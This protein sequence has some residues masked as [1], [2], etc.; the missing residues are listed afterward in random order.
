MQLWSADATVPLVGCKSDGMLGPQEPP[1]DGIIHL[2]LDRDI[3]K[4]MSYY[5]AQDEKGG[6]L[7]P[8]GWYCFGIYGSS[9]ASLFISPNPINQKLFFDPESKWKGFDGPIVLLSFTNGDTSGRFEVAEVI[10]RVFPDYAYFVRNVEEMFDFF[11]ATT[12]PYPDDLLNYKSKGV[13]E[14]RT[15]AQSEGLGA[16]GE[17][18]RPNDR[19]ID[20]VAMLT[21]DAPNLVMLSVRLP[22]ELT[23]LVQ[24]I[25][26]Q[27]ELDTK[28]VH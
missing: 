23:K 15:A 5:T 3:A 7:A 11:E 24:P 2:D 6:A 4:Y 28:P 1:P 20:G 17:T 8:R 22:E 19:Q 12:E 10:S 9:G 14:F 25:V 21:G 13:V 27:A 26:S 18:I 16:R